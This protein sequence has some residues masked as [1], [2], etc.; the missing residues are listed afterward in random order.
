MLWTKQLPACRIRC[1]NYRD[2]G[3]IASRNGQVQ[4]IRILLSDERDNA[5]DFVF[6]LKGELQN[7]NIALIQNLTGKRTQE[8]EQS[9]KFKIYAIDRSTTS[10]II[11][12][13]SSSVYFPENSLYENLDLRYSSAKG[14][15]SAVHSIHDN[16]TPLHKSIKLKL[17]Y[18][19]NLEAYKSK[20]LVV[21]TD[22][23]GRRSSVGGKAEGNYIVCSVSNF[24][25]YTVDIDT[26]AP[27]CKA[28]NFV[29]GKKIKPK[30]RSIQVRISDNLS[31]ISSYN[32]YLNDKWLLAEYD[33]KSGTLIMA[34]EDFPKG[35]SELKIILSD[36]KNNTSTHRFIVVR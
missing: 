20:A 14:K 31:G 30:Q 27:V 15:F 6:Y 10:T 4:E 33:G 24:G 12:P 35:R 3:V 34:A 25:T 17:R 18:S 9:E 32:A 8:T 21:S 1:V 11:L 13:D 5:S 28:K 26:V 7:P 23:K 22:G 29:S 19:K 16:R 2:G 36:A